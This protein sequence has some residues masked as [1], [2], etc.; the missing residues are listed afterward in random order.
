MHL[1]TVHR[2]LLLPLAEL[3]L[4]T[5]VVQLRHNGLYTINIQSRAVHHPHKH[6]HTNT[7]T[8]TH[9]SHCQCFLSLVFLW[10]KS[11]LF[12]LHCLTLTNTHLLLSTQAVQVPARNLFCIFYFPP[13]SLHCLEPF[14]LSPWLRRAPVPPPLSL[15]LT[16]SSTLSLNISI[17]PLS[18]SLPPSFP[19][20]ST[21]PAIT[22]HIY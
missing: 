5:H 1:N 6:T 21:L 13:V 10:N 18:T 19:S 3:A 9:T 8:H 14:T 4:I 12:C 17:W 16:S 7:H 20:P 2:D 15:T 22:N 11:N